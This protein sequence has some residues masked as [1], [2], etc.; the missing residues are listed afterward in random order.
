MDQVEGIYLYAMVDFDKAYSNRC[1][2]GDTITSIYSSSSSEIFFEKNG[3]A[4]GV[5]FTNVKGE[6]IA[7]VVGLTLS[8]ISMKTGD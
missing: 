2:V 7:H 1:Q 4:L 6:D 3:V 8:A 5:A